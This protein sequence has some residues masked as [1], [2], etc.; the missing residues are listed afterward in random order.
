MTYATLTVLC[1]FE[2]SMLDGVA[3]AWELWNCSAHTHMWNKLGGLLIKSQNENRS[4]LCT[5]SLSVE[6]Y[7]NDHC[8]HQLPSSLISR[9]YHPQDQI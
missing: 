3:A 9:R 1:S 4:V 5:F 7:Q 8:L 2:Q 6:V